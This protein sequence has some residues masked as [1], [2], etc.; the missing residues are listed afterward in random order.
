MKDRLRRIMPLGIHIKKEVGFFLGI[1]ISGI[2]NSLSVLVRYFSILNGFYEI[3][4]SGNRY[5]IENSV[6]P[7]FKELLDDSEKGFIV[8][9]VCLAGLVVYH[10]FYHYQESK[11]IYLMKRLPRKSELH[12]R[13]LAAPIL[14]SVVIVATAI[15]LYAV[16]YAIYLLVTPPQCLPL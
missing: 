12:K 7:P 8:A 1:F 9:I 6:M 11:A 2:L 16:Y 4:R 14:G 10:Y 5:L 3:D 15:F 13:C